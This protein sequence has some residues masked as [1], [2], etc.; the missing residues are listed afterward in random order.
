[1]IYRSRNQV[2]YEAAGLGVRM[3]NRRILTEY[4]R[5]VTASAVAF[6]WLM[7]V[8]VA[9]SPFITI[10]PY[11]PTP[12]PIRYPVSIQETGNALVVA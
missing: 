9:R 5:K 4:T 8:P 1:M 3:E 11:Q 10:L 12:S 2:R 7:R 6:V